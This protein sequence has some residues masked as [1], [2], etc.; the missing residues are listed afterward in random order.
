[1]IYTGIS[2]ELTALSELRAKGAA[3]PRF[4]RLAEITERN[5]GL[6]STEA[7]RYLLENFSSKA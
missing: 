4:L 3:E 6:W 1:M 5:N 7:E 2:L